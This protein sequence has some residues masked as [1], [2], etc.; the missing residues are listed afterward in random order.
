MA[1]RAI[2]AF[3]E[4]EGLHQA[5][6]VDITAY[7]RLRHLFRR[8]PLRLLS[9]NWLVCE[10]RLKSVNLKSFFFVLLLEILRNKFR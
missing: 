3:V 7:V 5:D 2:E 4:E 8:P 10:S 9:T 6:V 1:Q